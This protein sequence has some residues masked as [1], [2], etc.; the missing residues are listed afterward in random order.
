MIKVLCLTLIAVSCS[1]ATLAVQDQNR[2]ADAIYRVEGGAKARK[3]YGIL[4]VNVKTELE[5]RK[6]CINTINNNFARWQKQTAQSNFLDFLANRYCPPSVDRVGNRNWKRNIKS[7][8][9]ASECA[10]LTNQKK[11]KG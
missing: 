4:S 11:H 2:I 1:G 6:V 10:K 9:G 8:L 7:I 5:A 3:P